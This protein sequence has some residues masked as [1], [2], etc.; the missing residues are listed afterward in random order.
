MNIE[1]EPHT[2]DERVLQIFHVSNCPLS[3][4]EVYRIG[5][6]KYNHA[7]LLTSV[8]RAICTLTGLGR[9]EKTGARVDGMYGCP[10]RVWTLKSFDPGG[11]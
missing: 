2:Q 11:R 4:S 5:R 8:R 10:E 7:W 1:M 6:E 3:P 9:L